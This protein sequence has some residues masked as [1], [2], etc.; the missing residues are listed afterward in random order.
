MLMINDLEKLREL[1][2][3]MVKTMIDFFLRFIRCGY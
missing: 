1:N 3:I 2:N